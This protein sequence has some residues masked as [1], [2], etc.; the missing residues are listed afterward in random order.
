MIRL[1][2]TGNKKRG[3]IAFCIMLNTI[4]HKTDR[5]RQKGL[6]EK[7]ELLLRKKLKRNKLMFLV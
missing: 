1:K 3:K 7:E 6:K 5:L 4:K 2:K